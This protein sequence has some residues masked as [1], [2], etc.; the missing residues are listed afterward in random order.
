MWCL[1]H[2]LDPPNLGLN[3]VLS[4]IGMILTKIGKLFYIYSWKYGWTIQNMTF[5]RIFLLAWQVHLQENVGQNFH[6]SNMLQA[7]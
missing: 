4:G 3:Y 5:A 2:V 6:H 1:P 7:P